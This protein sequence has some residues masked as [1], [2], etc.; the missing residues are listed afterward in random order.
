MWEIL[1]LIVVIVVALLWFS[2][3]VGGGEI[4]PTIL[5][6][7]IKDHIKKTQKSW[8]PGWMAIVYKGNEEFGFNNLLDSRTDSEQK[9]H[10]NPYINGAQTTMPGADGY[11]STSTERVSKP[12]WEICRAWGVAMYHMSIKN[13]GSK[14]DYD[15]I[16]VE[17]WRKKLLCDMLEYLVG[18]SKSSTT[19]VETIGNFTAFEDYIKSNKVYWSNYVPAQLALI[20]QHAPNMQQRSNNIDQCIAKC[21][22]DN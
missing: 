16:I 20:M 4:D 10:P 8:F 21:R 7:Y 2:K 14:K 17:N 22:N 11:Y 6:A 5:S 13:P 9:I 15:K 18:L 12:R 19:F 1:L 3:I